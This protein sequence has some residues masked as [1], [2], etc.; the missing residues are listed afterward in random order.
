MPS[1]NL[2]AGKAGMR[3]LYAAAERVDFEA[4]AEERRRAVLAGHNPWVRVREKGEHPKP[5]IAFTPVTP[6][7][8][9]LSS[10]LL[11][12]AERHA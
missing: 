7:D 3:H 6:K 8:G 10:W 9:R 12:L 2:M 5:V 1:V 11:A 4:E